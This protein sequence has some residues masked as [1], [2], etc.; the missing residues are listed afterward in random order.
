MQVG[1]VA[2]ALTI[3][4]FA[5]ELTGGEIEAMSWESII[6]SLLAHE[7]PNFDGFLIMA[8]LAPKKFHCT[9]SHS[10]LVGFLGG[11]IVWFIN[12]AWAYIFWPS[13]FLHYLADMPSSVGIPLFLPFSKKRF[14]FNLWA[15]TGYFGWVSFKGTYEQAWTWILE[16]GAFTVLFVRLYIINFWPFG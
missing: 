15:D 5:P 10:L 7:F 9:W 1:H 3:A 6:V 2:V 14:S 4:S 12:P 13:V 16:G 8:G 11:L